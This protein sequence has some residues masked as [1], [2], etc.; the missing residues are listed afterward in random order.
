MPSP[1][2][3][4]LKGDDYQHL[5]AWREVLGLRAYGRRPLRVCVEVPKAGAL[6]DVVTHFDGD[7]FYYQVKFHVDHRQQYDSTSLMDI[8]SGSKHSLLQKIYKGWKAISDVT[9]SPTA[10]LM[11]NWAWNPKDPF[12][13]LIDG[14]NSKM[15]EEFFSARENTAIGR[16]RQDWATH[17]GVTLTELETFMR[18]FRI[19]LGFGCTDELVEQV[20]ERMASIGLKHNDAAVYA[21]VAQVRKWIKSG[22][23]VVDD[24]ALDEAIE[25][26]DLRAKDPEKSAT[27]HLH[28]IVHRSFVDMAD[29]ELDWV[30]HFPLTATGTRA[31]VPL[32]ENAWQASMLPELLDLRKQ[33]DQVPDLRLLKMRGQ[34]RLAPWIATGFV[35]CD[36]AGYVLEAILGDQHC[37]TDVAPSEDFDLAHPIVRDIEGEGSDLAV[38]ISVSVDV[39]EDVMSY[40][41][42]QKGFGQAIFLAP[43]REVGRDAIRGCGDLVALARKVKAIVRSHV[44]RSKSDRIGVFYSGPAAGALFIGH[45]LNAVASEVQIYEDT[46]AG[47]ALAFTLG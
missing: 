19:R 41:D 3:S 11:T 16:R 46:G 34:A 15:S 4:R 40:L 17:L 30:D 32:V 45:Q 43:D 23:V 42:G 20:K 1:S 44:R 12:A 29:Y 18:S 36:T 31:R 8:P 39:E 28:T 47:Y 22:V 14:T 7:S 35:F 13:K 26:F 5:F 2:S 21:G 24:A 37:R 6:D 27:V 33:I 10:V 38:G 9:E 25:A